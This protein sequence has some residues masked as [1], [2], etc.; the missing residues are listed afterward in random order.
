MPPF[1]VLFSNWKILTSNK[2][3]PLFLNNIKLSMGILYH[4]YNICKL[5]FSSDALLDMVI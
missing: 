5:L 4:C 2:I 3:K 1:G